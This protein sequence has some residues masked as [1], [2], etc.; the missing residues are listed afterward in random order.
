MFSV[1]LPFMELFNEENQN[2][3]K[4]LK[5][6]SMNMDF[7]S[8]YSSLRNECQAWVDKND[9]SITVTLQTVG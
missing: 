2:L 8:L 7:S 4:A 1:V 3:D 9:L 6:S 5:G